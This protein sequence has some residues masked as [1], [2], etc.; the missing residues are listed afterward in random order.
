[1]ASV[2]ILIPIITLALYLHSKWDRMLNHCCDKFFDKADIDHDGTVDKKELYSAVLEIYLHINY[3]AVPVPPPSREY[4]EEVLMGNHVA[5]D[6]PVFRRA[7]GILL[8]QAAGRVSFRLAVYS[9]SPLA[10]YYIVDSTESIWA[11]TFR[12]WGLA[13]DLARETCPDIAE[14]FFFG[15]LLAPFDE[16]WLSNTRWDCELALVLSVIPMLNREVAIAVV[17]MVLIFIAFPLS[18]NFADDWAKYH[19]EANLQRKKSYNVSYSFLSIWY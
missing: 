16:T 10:A 17:G 7:V 5:L 18:I 3:S 9:V 13:Y 1:M 15:G 19:V 12:I 14:R 6:R 2:A 8:R 11:F 4:V